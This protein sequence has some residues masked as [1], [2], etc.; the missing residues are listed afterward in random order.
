VSR[1]PFLRRR[2]PFAKPI[3]TYVEID[4]VEHDVAV[5]L[6]YQPAEPDVNVGE[7]LEVESVWFED[8]GCIMDKMSE[9]EVEALK[10]RLWDDYNVEDDDGC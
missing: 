8:E 4:G 7:S 3:D 5:S 10:Q 2:D 9:A 1:I 6:Y